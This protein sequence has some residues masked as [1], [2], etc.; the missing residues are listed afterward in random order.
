V[1]LPLLFVLAFANCI[2]WLLRAKR[3][4]PQE[5]RLFAFRRYTAREPVTLFG[6]IGKL[7]GRWLHRARA[8]ARTPALRG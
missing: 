3:E 4:L 5:L 8:Q 6:Q 7:A 2:Y 1:L